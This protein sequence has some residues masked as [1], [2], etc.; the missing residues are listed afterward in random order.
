MPDHPSPPR[1]PSPRAS[2]LCRALAGFGA[3]RHPGAHPAAWVTAAGWR[4]PASPVPTRQAPT[5]LRTGRRPLAALLCAAA[6][7]LAGCDHQSPAAGQA[8]KG[9]KGTLTV[10]TH[11]SFELPAELLQRFEQQSGY[12][13]KTT[14]AGDAGVA[15]QLVL[16]KANPRFD[17]V[18]GIDTYSAGLAQREGVLQDHA[19]AHLPP[20]AR[21]YVLPGLTPV[22]LGDVCINIDTAW[23]RAHKQAPP[24][25]F[26]DL[27]KP[28]Y[29]RLLVLPNPATS[30]P[31]FAMLAGIH[32]LKGDGAEAWL[33]QL[34][35]GGTRVAAGW[36]DA[37]NVQFSGGEGKG[38]YPLVLSY[39]SSPAASGG[40]TGVVEATC[41][42]Q[43]EYAGVVQG[44]AQAEG[45]RAFIDFL[46][47]PEVQ[48]AIPEA[49][50]VHPV[51]ERVPLPAAWQQHARLAAH[52][53]L[54]D[55]AQVAQQRRAWLKQWQALYESRP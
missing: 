47:S 29:A 38:A 11:D 45:A 48:A 34:L 22:D 5:P 41:V 14:P 51:D 46:L 8:H 10:L 7:T 6:L 33:R 1:P 36:S 27:L 16:T 25:G 55:A 19:P 49:M 32:T 35:A 43:V 44:T 17:A 31:G 4:P 40:A 15:N 24:T 21:P 50:Y 42:R 52:P 3:S 18:Y 54:P 30:S 39:A 13:L 23:F 12:R 9:G 20:S 26:D 2:R 28:E 53:V 37:Y